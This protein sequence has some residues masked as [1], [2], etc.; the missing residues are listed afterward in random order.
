MILE[1]ALLCLSLNIYYEAGY[2]PPEAQMAVALVTL[3]RA[4]HKQTEVCNVVFAKKQFSWTNNIQ[5]LNKPIGEAWVNS[6]KIAKKALK[7]KSNIDF[8]HGATH[9]YAEY[10]DPPEWTYDMEYVGQYGKH[11]FYRRY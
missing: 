11:L 3:N 6:I 8:T 1:S 5:I 7:T 4:H 9:F 2:E 10:I